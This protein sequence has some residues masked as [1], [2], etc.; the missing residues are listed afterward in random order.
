MAV[1]TAVFLTLTAVLLLPAPKQDRARSHAGHEAMIAP[2]A[3]EAKRLEI[4]PGEEAADQAAAHH[5]AAPADGQTTPPSASTATP[6]GLA[7]VEEEKTIVLTSA[8]DPEVT[9][10]TPQGPL[11]VIGGDG[12]KPWQVYA[13]P[14]A[15]GSIPH[16]A[17]IVAPL[18]GDRIMANAAIT[19]L[20]GAITLAIDALAP[21][22]GQWF[23]EAR[24]AGHET[25][26]LLAAEPLDY[27][28]SD[29]GSGLLL[30]GLPA[31]ENI[32]RL[33][34][35]LRQGAGYTG[36]MTLT[37]TRFVIE[38]QA[39][40]PVLAEIE[41]RGLA[42]L[43]ARISERSLLADFAGQKQMPVAVIDFR[44][45]ADLA[46][47]EIDQTLAQAEM[48]ARQAGYAVCLVTATSLALDRLNRWSSQLPDRGVRLVP[49]SAVLL[50]R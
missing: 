2:A 39:L 41:K 25:L 19:R 31:A 40:R 49:F 11:P 6:P 17:V 50:R 12:R 34:D 13:R 43:D 29:P 9:E 32:R 46:P 26:L 44:I 24:K 4:P 8:P 45:D 30:I 14:Y 16:I 37:G 28:A 27:P 15:A 10:E 36:I 35:M 42:I 38:P 18:G 5:D 1:L 22:A 47:A 21:D 20:P 7:A 48:Q 33:L 3:T 23:G